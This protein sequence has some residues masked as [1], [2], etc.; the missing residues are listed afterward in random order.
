MNELEPFQDRSC[1]TEQ[2]LEDSSPA[3]LH[4][5]DEPSRHETRSKKKTVFLIVIVLL[6]VG[7]VSAGITWLLLR[8]NLENT[9]LK[10]ES[11]TEDVISD[12]FDLSFFNSPEEYRKFLSENGSAYNQEFLSTN[13]PSPQV[14]GSVDES[15]PK[16]PNQTLNLQHLDRDTPQDLLVTKNFLIA[17]SKTTRINTPEIA[18]DMNPISNLPNVINDGRIKIISKA[19]DSLTLS[20]YLEESG[21]FL[22]IGNTLVVVE[23]KKITGFDI[24]FTD[25]P[26]KI[27]SLDFDSRS[28]VLEA[29]SSIDSIVLLTHTKGS[30]TASCPIFVLKEV[31]DPIFD[32]SDLFY[33]KIEVPIDGTYGL[34]I[35]DAK[36]GQVKAKTGYVASSSNSFAKFFDSKL[37]IGYRFQPDLL[38]QISNFYLSL[39]NDLLP[40]EQKQAIESVVSTNNSDRSKLV[41]M[42]S[43]VSRWIESSP[44]ADRE[45]MAIN[46]QNKLSEFTKSR[47][48]EFHKS[49]LV[50]IP[51][52]F[53]LRPLR[54]VVEGQVEPKSIAFDGNELT[55]A[56]EHPGWNQDFQEI[57]V[58]VSKI[59]MDSN[60]AIKQI[61]QLSITDAV[62]F[63]MDNPSSLMIAAFNQHPHRL[64]DLVN[65]QEPKV[66]DL[67]DADVIVSYKQDKKIGLKF[68]DGKLSQLFLIAK[69]Q[70]GE[71]KPSSLLTLEQ[72]VVI[73]D[74]QPS[75]IVYDDKSKLLVFNSDDLVLVFKIDTTQIQLLGKIK[76]RPEAVE[77]SDYIYLLDSDTITAHDMVSLTEVMKVLI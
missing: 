3:F 71:W 20:S 49:G 64:V 72:P 18:P 54:V 22:L 5:Q 69:S 27:W 15:K 12:N 16:L 60:P 48:T 67:P 42:E 70:S 21:K 9:N 40:Q 14:F 24:A 37:V 38:I 59:S 35:L 53:P 31:K 36:N 47:R 46:F 29:K 62:A 17:N 19:N 73:S 66:V 10:T 11:V 75:D 74:W 1:L 8:N 39:P 33:P 55:V 6:V 41:A 25:K 57:L 44:T 43:V 52:S 56:G 32:C 13:M 2:K 65:S 23:A 45:T 58:D 7:A 68:E 28:Q 61:K 50:I 34:L 51:F 4:V 26:N 77:I 63:S 30:V 76:S